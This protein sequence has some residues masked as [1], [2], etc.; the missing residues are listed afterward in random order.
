MLV[1][2]LLLL[3]MAAGGG[4]DRAFAAS[5]DAAAPVA[6]TPLNLNE[7][8]PEQLD[9]LPGIGP[10]LAERIVAYRDANGPFT[11]IEQLNEVKGIGERTLAKLRPYLTLE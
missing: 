2:L 7:S 4:G 3:G 11:R 10:A 1:L 6:G 9:E 8:T 5:R